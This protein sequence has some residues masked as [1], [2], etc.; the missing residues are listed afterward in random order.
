MFAEDPS[1]FLRDFGVPC[2]CGA[3]PFSGLLDLPDDTLNMGGVNVLS[4]M[5]VLEV[6]FSDVVAGG[7]ATG[8][9]ITV[10]ATTMG[11][12]VLSFKVRDVLSI[13]DGV[14]NHITL[15]KV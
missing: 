11:L 14:I 5:Y 15:S 12:G 8:S 1:I 13:D 2:S 4:T 7:L 3:Y 10:D 9:A 6:K